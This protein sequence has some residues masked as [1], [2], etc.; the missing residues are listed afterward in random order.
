MTPTNVSEVDVELGIV[1]PIIRTDPALRTRSGVEQER[2]RTDVGSVHVSVG[3][4]TIPQA[5][6]DA[7]RSQSLSGLEPANH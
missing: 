2:E 6:H 7:S 1:P 5:A 4:A 3:P